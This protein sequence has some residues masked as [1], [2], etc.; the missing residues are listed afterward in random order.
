MVWA[1]RDRTEQVLVNLF[2]NAIKYSPRS[3]TV[4]VRVTEESDVVKIDVEDRGIG[5]P[6][7]KIRQIFDRFYRV[8][9]KEGEFTGLGLGLYISAEIISRE[10]GQMWVESEEK[11]GST[12]Y[13]TLPTKRNNE[14]KKQ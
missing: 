9:S 14:Y 2:S 6:K 3:D 7:N 13:F 5:I 10:N 1:D 12:F 8:D 4:L 11:I